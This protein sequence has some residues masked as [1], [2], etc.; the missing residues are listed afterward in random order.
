MTAPDRDRG[1]AAPVL[2]VPDPGAGPV[3]LEAGVRAVRKAGP[4]R[5]L[6]LSA[7]E[8]AT[9]TAV[10][11]FLTVGIPGAVVRRP[12]WIA[13]GTTPTRAAPSS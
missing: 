10:G 4:I 3:R 13:S 6:S 1:D 12:F 9:R 5:T 7:P 2:R 11:Q 8:L